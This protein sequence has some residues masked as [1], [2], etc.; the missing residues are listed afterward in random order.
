MTQSAAPAVLLTPGAPWQA[1]LL[2][3]PRTYGKPALMTAST[4][5]AKTVRLLRTADLLMKEVKAKAP[6]EQNAPE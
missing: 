2:V 3:S 4:S 6:P 5:D 1:M